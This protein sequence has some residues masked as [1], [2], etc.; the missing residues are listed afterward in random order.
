MKGQRLTRAGE[1]V[2]YWSRNDHAA[3]MGGHATGDRHR[4]SAAVLLLASG[5]NS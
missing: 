2:L 3:L 5:G 1:P 4:T